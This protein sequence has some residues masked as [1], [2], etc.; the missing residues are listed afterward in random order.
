MG[1][2]QTVV[3]T[4]RRRIVNMLFLNRLLSVGL[5]LVGLLGV[6]ISAATTAKAGSQLFEASWTVKAFGNVANFC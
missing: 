5:F 2:V 4:P 3:R 6:G 1:M